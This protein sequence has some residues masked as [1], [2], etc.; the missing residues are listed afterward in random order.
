M[1][2]MARNAIVTDLNRCI[3]CFACELACKQH[4]NIDLGI[5]WCKVHIMGPYGTFPDIQQYWLPKN[6]QQCENA[7]CIDVCPTGASYRNEDGV[8]LVDAD[9]NGDIVVVRDEEASAANRAAH[10]THPEDGP[11]E[12]D[13][14][15]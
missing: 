10:S 2:S 4:N 6:C 9:D 12:P 11:V 15:E 1:P 5:N 7:P 13:A 8:V 14:V 3:G